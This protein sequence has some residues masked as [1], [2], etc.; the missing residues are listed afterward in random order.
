MSEKD[1]K[2]M[3]EIVEHV[4]GKGRN[5]NE[6]VYKEK[7]PKPERIVFGIGIG[8]NMY[9]KTPAEA[10]FGRLEGFES[11]LRHETNESTKKEILHKQK[12]F[13]DNFRE[14][15][16]PG[17][18]PNELIKSALE[19][20]QSKIT[21]RQEEIKNLE[22]EINEDKGFI[23]VI[24]KPYVDQIG[25]NILDDYERVVSTI[26]SLD[27]YSEMGDEGSGMGEE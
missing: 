9:Y 26:S 18:D 7:S 15:L 6:I 17:E 13:I 25:R 12:L 19:Y 5:L 24:G 22:A 14:D 11:D 1:N 20:G 21:S 4:Q 8:P 27:T 16:L 3:E 2:S 10:F 23:A